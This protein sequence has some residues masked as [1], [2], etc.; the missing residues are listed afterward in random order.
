MQQIVQNEPKQ[1]INE[2]STNS[3]EAA[4]QNTDVSPDSQAMINAAKK[5]RLAQLLEDAQKK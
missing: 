3:T 5:A 4:P 1:I 2:A